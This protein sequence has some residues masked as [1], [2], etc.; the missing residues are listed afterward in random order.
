MSAYSLFLPA[1]ELGQAHGLGRDDP[2]TQ[3]TVRVERQKR[4]TTSAVQVR[5]R[6]ER[7]AAVGL[8]ARRDK[9]A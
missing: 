3:V 8:R 7:H 9:Q 2:V 6:G 5:A 4:P 1:T